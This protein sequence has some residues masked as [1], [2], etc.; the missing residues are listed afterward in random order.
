MRLQVHWSIAQAISFLS[1]LQVYTPVSLLQRKASGR[2]LSIPIPSPPSSSHLSACGMSQHET[3]LASQSSILEKLQA[4]PAAEVVVLHGEWG[5]G[6][7]TVVGYYAQQLS[8][9][10]SVIVARGCVCADAEEGFVLGVWRRGWCWCGCGEGCGA[11]SHTAVS[12]AKIRRLAYKAL[13]R[14]S[15]AMAHAAFVHILDAQM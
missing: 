1:H 11:M 15:S 3:P 7:T 13:D 5:C 10:S 9:S 2:S 6:K 12:G 14:I 4:R 8:H